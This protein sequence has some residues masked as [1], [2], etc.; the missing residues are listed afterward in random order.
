MTYNWLVSLLPSHGPDE[1][2]RTEL[3]LASQSDLIDSLEARLIAAQR[4]ISVLE[5][6]LAV[7]RARTARLRSGCS[8]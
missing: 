6:Q 7:E 4:R 1:R 8:G 2:Q 3:R 5:M